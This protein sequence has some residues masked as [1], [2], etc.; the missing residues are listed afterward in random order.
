MLSNLSELEPEANCYVE[1]SGGYISPAVRG[2]KAG[3]YVHVMLWSAQDHTL[4]WWQWVLESNIL[5]LSEV[6]DVI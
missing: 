4:R 5:Q 3:N 2:C 6:E 1:H